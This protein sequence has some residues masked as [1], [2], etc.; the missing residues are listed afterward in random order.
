ME[1][2]VTAAGCRSEEFSQLFLLF[3]GFR[4]GRQEVLA[5]EEEGKGKIG[6]KVVGGAVEDRGERGEAVQLGDGTV[7]KRRNDVAIEL[8]ALEDVGDPEDEERALEIVLKTTKSEL[9]VGAVEKLQGKGDPVPVEG[10]GGLAHDRE[11]V[12]FGINLGGE[13][14]PGVM[15]LEGGANHRS[16]FDPVAMPPLLAEGVDD[17]L[18][19]E[20]RGEHARR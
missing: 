1:S 2:R 11:G 16:A 7:D 4:D 14:D 12:E 6:E 5:F 3:A 17:G 10:H 9:L 8:F 19:L 20:G 18:E 13:I 15:G